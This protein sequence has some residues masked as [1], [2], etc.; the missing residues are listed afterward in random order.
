MTN[1][2]FRNCRYLITTASNDSIL[3]DAAVYIEG[4]T[5]KAVGLSRDIEQQYVNE[6]N[7]EV[8]DCKNKIV[9]PGLIDTH[10]HLTLGVMALSYALKPL[11]VNR[12]GWD[13]NKAIYN[14]YYPLWGWLDAQSAYDLAL[15]GLA[16]SL[17]YGTTTVADAS[18]FPD[19]LYK[20]AAESG[21]RFVLNPQMLSFIQ[22]QDKLDEQGYLDQ[23]EECIQQ[24]H[25]SHDG[26]ITV[27]VHPSI[28]WACTKNMLVKGMQ[29]AEDYDIQ[30]STHLLCAQEERQKAN[31]IFA[32]EGGGIKHLQ[33]LGLLQERTLLIHY[34]SG[35]EADLEIALEAGCSFSHCPES[36]VG[37]NADLLYV[38]R[39]LKE[40]ATVGLGTDLPTYSLFN[41]MNLTQ[42]L[43]SIMPRMIRG[44]ESSVPLELA[45]SGGAKA[46]RLKDLGTIEPEKKADIITLDLNRNTKFFPLHPNLIINSIVSQGA[47]TEVTDAMVNGVLLR[48]D[49]KFTKLDEA[50]LH[51]RASEW[52]SKFSN[53]FI[54]TNTT[55]RSMAKRIHDPF[56]LS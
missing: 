35:D 40:G 20:A 41:Q 51:A 27:S 42:M 9:L 34:C 11:P 53:D 52:A 17:K 13:L 55:G 22:L 48:R 43:H 2:L 26:L 29:L 47:G 49:N 15:F 12:Q 37:L 6:S 31:R 25:N 10:N 8:I 28:P 19:S 44:L 21:M 14:E 5:I 4:N 46:L 32:K 18:P 1:T 3:E 23:T 38:P 24:Y 16:N 30:F 39:L 45:T 33:N 56:D 50:S 36:T 7:L 54:E